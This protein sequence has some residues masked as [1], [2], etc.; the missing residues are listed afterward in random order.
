VA[1]SVL[2][3]L[4]VQA[5]SVAT[6]DEPV[7]LGHEESLVE[8][9]KEV[10]REAEEK[11]D[12]GEGA[13]VDDE[14][15]PT[16]KAPPLNMEAFR[17]RVS[18]QFKKEEKRNAEDLGESPKVT[19]QGNEDRARRMIHLGSLLE[20]MADT[21]PN[22]NAAVA[23]LSQAL[24][25]KLLM[26]ELHPDTGSFAKT[27]HQEDE[28]GETHSNENL[29]SFKK[30]ISEHKKNM[31]EITKYLLERKKMGRPLTTKEDGELQKFYYNRASTI[32][33]KI[34]LLKQGDKAPSD[35]S[36]EMVGRDTAEDDLAQDQSD[37]EI[38]QLR[39]DAKV[40]NANAKYN[41][42]MLAAKRARMK[43]ALQ[44]RQRAY[45]ESAKA[46]AQK[47]KYDSKVDRTEAKYN[48]ALSDELLK[49]KHL[50][51]LRV[52]GA[53][54]Q[55]EQADMAA[56]KATAEA[57][58][59]D[60]EAADAEKEAEVAEKKAE[61]LEKQAQ[62]EGRSIP[63]EDD[64][65]KKDIPLTVTPHTNS[66]ALLRY[67]QTAIDE[68]LKISVQEKQLMQGW[69]LKQG[70]AL[71]SKLAQV[72]PDATWHSK[73][74]VREE[75]Y[76]MDTNKPDRLSSEWGS[77]HLQG[78]TVMRDF[79]GDVLSHHKS[80]TKLQRPEDMHAFNIFGNTAKIPL[81]FAPDTSAPMQS[82]P[83]MSSD[84][85]EDDDVK[86]IPHKGAL[87]AMMGIMEDE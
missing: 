53:A 66:K 85:G 40:A 68:H 7:E 33:K 64:T 37:A 19:P 75:Q 11:D 57:D 43:A 56:E 46:A 9:M 41:N 8:Q 31:A 45:D 16:A 22:R 86:Q 49:E 80:H 58:Q 63:A 69:F 5:S 51:E 13:E 32:L 6:L 65:A 87:S 15:K 23:T 17:K 21:E 54:E 72:D 26:D 83:A 52:Q 60:K 18:F 3:C 36:D 50:A 42:K 14:V 71:L 10:F 73:G 78:S 59:A 76:E 79:M 39:F 67:L 84:L 2:L 48:K 81:K 20:S 24:H 4:V 44:S 30:L 38:E 35:S 28:L 12:L 61:E 47:S 74:V 62:S 55:K 29:E 34:V 25:T 70:S 1:A 82:E 77:K 27:E